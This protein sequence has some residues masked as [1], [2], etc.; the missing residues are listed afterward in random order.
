MMVRRGIAVMTALL[1]LPVLVACVV[2]ERIAPGDELVLRPGDTLVARTPRGTLRVEALSEAQRRYTWPGGTRTLTLDG[3]TE[4]WYGAQGAYLAA[5]PFND[6]NAGENS[7]DFAS[8]RAL[9]YYVQA[10]PPTAYAS[11]GTTVSFAVAPNGSND[12]TVEKLCVDHHSPTELQSSPGSSFKWTH[13]GAS[14]QLIASY[15][16]AR[17]MTDPVALDEAVLWQDF[18]ATRLDN[19]GESAG[20]SCE[21]LGGTASTEA[22]SIAIAQTV[23]LRA[24]AAFS[25]RNGNGSLRVEAPSA[26][27]RVLHWQNARTGIAPFELDTAPREMTVE[28]AGGAMEQGVANAIA[29]RRLS[30]ASPYIVTYDEGSIDFASIDDFHAWLKWGDHGALYLDDRY[31]SASV[32]GGF[33]VGQD[34]SGRPMLAVGIGRVCIAGSPVDK[35][36]GA[37]DENVHLEGAEP[38]FGWSCP[39]GTLDVAREYRHGQRHHELDTPRERRLRKFLG[40]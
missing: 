40:I 4:P 14:P 1:G 29:C 27:T 19:F 22:P 11:D 21:L 34:S 28:L 32:I 20:T 31:G 24:G 5:T 18:D 6:T 35:L 33:H 36:P 16:C 38:P 3:R 23:A 30:G 15:G 9:E 26:T 2:G 37:D 17:T 7:Y 12:V 25:L 8:E 39:P 13:A 10:F